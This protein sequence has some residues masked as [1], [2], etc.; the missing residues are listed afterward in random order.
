MFSGGNAMM[1][2]YQPWHPIF[3]KCVSLDSRTMKENKDVRAGWV[4]T[5][6]V[7]RAPLL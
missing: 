1:N 2:G 4:G 7:N 6:S 3:D 5:R